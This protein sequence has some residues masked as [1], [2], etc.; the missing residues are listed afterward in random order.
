MGTTAIILAA[1]LIISIVLRESYRDWTEENFIFKKAGHLIVITVTL[2][3]L[4]IATE[5]ILDLNHLK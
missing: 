1:F 4:L 3:I 2:L 5:F